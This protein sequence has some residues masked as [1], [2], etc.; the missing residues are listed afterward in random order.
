MGV[1]PFYVSQTL[2]AML[3]TITQ[4]SGQPL[5]LTN[6]TYAMV[7]HNTTSSTQPDFNNSGTF[8]TYNASLGQVV[9]NWV[10]AD[11]STAGTYGL[12]IKITIGAGTYICDPI[13]FTVVSF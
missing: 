12:Y 6:A 9:Y 3:V 2:P 8:T 10:T 13:P 11:T 7:F 5:N 4:D 1:S